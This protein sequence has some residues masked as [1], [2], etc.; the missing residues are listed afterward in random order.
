[1]LSGDIPPASFALLN[2]AGE[3]VVSLALCRSG[4]RDELGRLAADQLS[5]GG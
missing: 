2:P 5:N 4:L 1:L 3:R